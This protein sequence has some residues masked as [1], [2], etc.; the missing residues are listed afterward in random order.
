MGTKAEE[1]PHI[2]RV[3]EKVKSHI[4]E[5]NKQITPKALQD[6]HETI[7]RWLQRHKSERKNLKGKNIETFDENRHTAKISSH[8]VLHLQQMLELGLTKTYP[9]KSLTGRI[10]K[11]ETGEGTSKPSEPTKPEEKTPEGSGQ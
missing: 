7:R 1:S 2:K 5:E 11:T 10:S 3:R 9:K 4:E 8:Y 6:T